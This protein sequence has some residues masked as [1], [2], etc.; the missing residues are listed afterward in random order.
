MNRGRNRSWRQAAAFLTTALLA[1]LLSGSA[2]RSNTATFTIFSPAAV[3]AYPAITDVT[4]IEVGVKFSADS[5]GFV[6]ALRFYKGV[7]NTGTHVGHLWSAS[8]QQLAEATFS[9]ETASG[10][11]Q[12]QLAEPVAISAHTTYVAS[13]WSPSGYFAYTPSYFTTG[14]DNPP[15]HAP[16]SGS[17]GGNGLYRYNSSGLPTS[18]YQAGNYWVDV[19]FSSG[20][21][22]TSAPG[23]VAVSPGDGAGAVAVGSSVTARFDEPV[24]PGTLTT[25]NVSLRDSG[26]DS[27]P[28]A[29]GYTSSSLT[30]MLTPNVPLAYSTTYTAT[31][32]GGA[33]GVTDTAGNALAEDYAWAFPPAAAPATPP[34]QGPG[35]PI[36]VVRSSADGFG[37]Y[38]AEILRTEGLNEFATTDLSNLSAAKLA[39]YQ[40]VI[41]GHAA[42]SDAQVSTLTTWVEGGGKL[43]AM[44]PDAKLAALLGLTSIGG[45]LTDGYLRVDTSSSPGAGITAATMQFHGSADRYATD[46]DTRAVATLYSDATTATTSP[47]VTLRSVG[48]SGGQAAAFAYDLA[49]SVVYTHQGNPAWAGQERDN[50]V[51]QGTPTIRSDD[52]FFGGSQPDYVDLDKVAIPQ[53]DEQQR[54]LAN[55]VTDMDSGSMPLP[56]LWY[57]PDGLKAAIVMTG[58]AHPNGQTGTEFAFDRFLS[59][60][61]SNCS[62]ADWTCVRE[63]AYVQQ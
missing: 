2:A 54:L 36:L 13:Y 47:A 42:L 46:A 48:S 8:G 29:V 26:G 9:G 60:S 17:S 5:D 12:V 37:D 45:T 38:L 16:S 7:A 32:K 40:V 31:I 10:W 53:A 57:F 56:R 62:L 33:G 49:R 20:S 11:Q 34:D 28:A 25:A 52:L 27:V 24:D 59:Q 3:P 55:L 4:P 41:L 22:D 15:L 35:G 58:D 18:S 30:V 23:V 63:T 43:V 6:T 21:A 50:A 19:V 44:R 1:V 51:D 14:V 39:G 61:P